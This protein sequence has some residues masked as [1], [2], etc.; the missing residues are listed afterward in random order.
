MW[1]LCSERKTDSSELTH[2]HICNIHVC[3][4]VEQGQ[5]V[6][7]K[8]NR[9]KGRGQ[10]GGGR[11][12][13]FRMSVKKASLPGDFWTKTLRNERV[14]HTGVWRECSRW[15]EERV[16]MLGRGSVSGGELDQRGDGRRVCWEVRGSTVP[17][18][19]APQQETKICHLLWQGKEGEQAVAQARGEATDIPVETLN[20]D[21]TGTV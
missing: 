18:F 16:Q 5:L 21:W 2:T 12:A 17:A 4:G 20:S 7:S 11:V 1:R 6:W 19:L 13:V 8:P 14:D 15:K 9:I 3:V 10:S